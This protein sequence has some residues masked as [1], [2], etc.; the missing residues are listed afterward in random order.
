MTLKVGASYTRILLSSF[1]L[2]TPNYEKTKTGLILGIFRSLVVC[3]M[4]AYIMGVNQK[5][6]I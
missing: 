4:F 6:Y 3:T 2:G 5:E 1:P